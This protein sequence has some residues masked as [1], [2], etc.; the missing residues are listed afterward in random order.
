MTMERIRALSER[1]KFMVGDK[2]SEEEGSEEGPHSQQFEFADGVGVSEF[3]PCGAAAAVGGCAPC[4]DNRCIVCTMQYI[5]DECAQQKKRS[6]DLECSG[7]EKVY[8]GAG[9]AR[10]VERD[11]ERLVVMDQGFWEMVSE[12]VDNRVGDDRQP[13]TTIS[14]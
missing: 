2:G 9:L 14:I 13:P 10:R 11:G 5:S 6:G 7:F 3:G 12:W 4:I 8:V 1:G